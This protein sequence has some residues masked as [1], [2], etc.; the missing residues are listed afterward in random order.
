MSDP[1]VKYVLSPFEGSINHGDT[2]GLKLYLQSTKGVYK[3]NYKIYI[4]V[5]NSK[6][7]IDHLL[8]IALKCGWGRLAFMV[9][10]ND[11]PRNIFRVV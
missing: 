1:V 2:T 10:T 11:V 7:I 9:G 8:S 6:Y 3:A 5:S 4:L